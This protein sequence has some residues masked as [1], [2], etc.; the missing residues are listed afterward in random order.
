MID[1]VIAAVILNHPHRLGPPARSVGVSHSRTADPVPVIPGST[2]YVWCASFQ[3][4][5]SVW[6]DLRP[7]M[8]QWCREVRP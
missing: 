1:T 6:G 7:F 2:R 3:L 4:E 8:R 5:P